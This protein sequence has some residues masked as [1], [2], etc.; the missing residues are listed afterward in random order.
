MKKA[1]RKSDLPPIE[2]RNPDGLYT[3]RS[4]MIRK[5]TPQALESERVV[6][7]YIRSTLTL[8]DFATGLHPANIPLDFTETVEMMR[9]YARSVSEGADLKPVEEMLTLQ[10]TVLDTMFNHLARQAFATK[11]LKTYQ[12]QAN[13]AL[14]AQNQARATWQT[15]AEIKF[16]KTL[17]IVG[18]A[19]ISQQQQVNNMAEFSSRAQEK[20]PK[21]SNEL[22]EIH[23]ER[24]LDNREE[25]Q[26]IDAHQ[27][28]E[29]MEPIDRSK[30]RKRKKNGINKR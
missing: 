19:N 30:D 21:I 23:N 7:P 9:T 11:H 3:K 27:N 20:L 6:F 4:D 8:R 12:L 2:T 15:L 24:Q 22:L 14:K 29:T 5:K 28:L 16:P 17:A 25:S 18:Q 1:T 10:A 26:T 13:L